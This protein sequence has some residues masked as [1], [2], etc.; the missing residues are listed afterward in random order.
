MGRGKSSAAIRYMNE[1]KGTKHFVYI[2]PFLDE[3]SRVCEACGFNQPSGENTT[4][5][6]QLKHLIHSGQNIA[7]THALFLLLDK[8]CLNLISD[9]R[10][11]LI[12]DE[13]LPVIER[14]NITSKDYCLLVEQ[15]T[16]S[17]DDNRLAWKDKEYTGR[18]SD[19]KELA[20]TGSLI[21]LDS[22]LLNILN[23]SLLKAFDEIFMLTYLFDGQYQKAYLDYYD[24]QYKV[25]GIE[26]DK[27]GHY[28]SDSPDAPPPLSLHGLVNIVSNQKRDLVGNKKYSL[29]KAWYAARSY[30]NPEIRTLRNG[31]R[32]FFQKETDSD[33]SNRLW[34]C[35]KRDVDNLVEAQSGR[36]RSNFLQ[37]GAR[38]TNQYREKINLAYM[39]N[40]FAD[41]NIIKFFRAKGVVL[42]PDKFALSEMLQWLW[43]S[44]IRDDRPINVCIPSKRMRTLLC[45]WMNSIE[46]EGGA[47]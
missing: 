13:S 23:P 1:H 25:V 32:Q 12:I 45:D 20:D 44:A 38:A 26:I 18:F 33:Q 7:T 4:K 43:R 27:E 30:S 8:E 31:L 11:T 35:Y 28:F 42:D 37:I 40:R 16:E 22:A 47:K 19:Y 34:T 3:V 14:L 5:L 15:L 36:F 6:A 39:V 17:G 2:T 41:P 9:K 10:Y 29:S 24:F 46:K 21:A